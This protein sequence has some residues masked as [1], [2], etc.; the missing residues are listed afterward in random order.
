M[1]M[2]GP[3]LLARRQFAQATAQL[4]ASGGGSQL[5]A[6]NGGLLVVGLLAV[7]IC[8]VDLHGEWSAD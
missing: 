3:R 7:E 4:I 8:S 5:L 2:V 6:A 1:I